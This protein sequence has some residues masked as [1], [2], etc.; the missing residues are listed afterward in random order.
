MKKLIKRILPVSVQGK[1]RQS[2]VNVQMVRNFLNDIRSYN[3][4]SA[5]ANNKRNKSTHRSELIF[6]YHKIEKGL[7]LSNPRVGF[8]EPAILYL[9]DSLEQYVRKYSWDETSQISLN[10]LYLYY[11]FNLRNNNKLEELHERLEKLKSS[12]G[13]NSLTNEGGVLDL[14][15]SDILKD[16]SIDFSKF[17][18]SRHSIR[19]FSSEEVPVELIKQAIK[20]A[21]KTPSV[22]NR[23]SSIVHIFDNKDKQKQALS[24]QNGNA[25]FGDKASKILL[26]TADAEDFFGA[27]ERNQAFIDGGM[28][29]MSLIYALHSLG[30]GSCALNLALDYR[31]AN[32]LKND[33]GI[34]QKEI[35]I[36][37]IAVGHIPESLKVAA[38]PRK[39]LDE[40][41]RIH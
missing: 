19:H 14:E 22:C 25:G 15:K 28:F 13:S 9:I 31:V 39:K 17:A 37:M 5:T 41:T 2:R 24:F 18:N 6:Y 16:S 8:G 27:G 38:S 20:M 30:V 21:Q 26:V 3:R 32:R 23:Q 34:K 40:I 12:L 11:D 35:L 4:L 10:T 29:A 33:M 7:A 1:I 36:M